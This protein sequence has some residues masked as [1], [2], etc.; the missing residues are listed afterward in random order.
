[1]ICKE[2]GNEKQ[3]V[4]GDM[5]ICKE[6]AKNGQDSDGLLAKAK[7]ESELNNL[8][9]A[10]GIPKRF[11]GC[12]MDSYS[13]QSQA[14]ISAKRKIGDY[15]LK[16]KS[17]QPV[18]GLILLS[19]VGLGK[20]LLACA[21]I[22]ELGFNFSSRLRTFSALTLE[23]KDSM[24][25]RESE[26]TEKEFISFYSSIEFLIIDEIGIQK[27]TDAEMMMLNQIINGRYNNMLPT[28]MISNLSIAELKLAVGER[29]V[30]RLRSEGGSVIILEG[31]SKRGLK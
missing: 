20:T 11:N 10:A 28:M 26:F 15:L 8:R 18:G 24:F 25:N 30:D 4:F 31:K 29:V 19:N 21:M 23:L 5:F 2:C 22:E 12:A 1:M 16:V 6:C 17:K 14:E 9:I 13:A 3:R 7:S 27:G